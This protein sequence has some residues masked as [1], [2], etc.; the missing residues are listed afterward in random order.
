VGADRCNSLS[1]WWNSRQAPSC[2]PT[3]QALRDAHLIS[4]DTARRG[5]APDGVACLFVTAI[6][7]GRP[8]AASR[9]VHAK[10]W[11]TIHQP[12]SEKSGFEMHTQPRSYCVICLTGSPWYR[13]SAELENSRHRRQCPMRLVPPPGSATMTKGREAAARRFTA[14]RLSYLSVQ[15]LPPPWQRNRKPGCDRIRSYLWR[16]R[17]CSGNSNRHRRRAPLNKH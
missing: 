12:V 13:F 2:W 10:R 9:K 11:T 7:L 15:P 6:W 5:G 14:L 4:C 3:A 1:S 17:R 16:A 8:L